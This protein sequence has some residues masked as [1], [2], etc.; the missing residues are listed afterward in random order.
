MRA[1]GREVLLQGYDC[2][3]G[4]EGVTC[5]NEKEETRQREIKRGRKEGKVGGRKHKGE[6]KDKENIKNW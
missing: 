4:M 1:E 2:N 3:R 5:K 6:G